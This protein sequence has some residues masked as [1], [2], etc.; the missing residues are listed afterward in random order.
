MSRRHGA[1]LVLVV[2]IASGCWTVSG[3]G[4]SRSGFNPLEGAITPANVATLTPGWSWTVPNDPTASVQGP[5]VVP[6][7]AYVASG[8]EVFALDPATGVQLWNTALVSDPNIVTSAATE[9]SRGHGRVYASVPTAQLGNS[10]GGT[11]AVDAST[12][13]G[14]ALVAREARSAVV[15]RDGR[16]VGGFEDVDPTGPF[17]PF[18]VAGY[19]VTDVSDPSKSWDMD[20]ATGSIHGPAVALPEPV[21]GADR[22]FVS[23][24]N[25]VSAY[26]LTKPNG[27]AETR[28]EYHFV[29]CP[30]LWSV[31]L[32]AAVNRRVT[33]SEDGRTLVLTAGP[34]IAGLDPADGSLDWFASKSGPSS[35]LTVPAVDGAT[36]FAVDG[37]GKLWAYDRDGCP[38]GQ[39]TPQWSADTGGDVVV[40]PTIA[41]GVVY[42]ATTG[43]VI[44]AFPAAG[45]GASTCSNLWEGSVASAPTGLAVALGRV[46]VATISKGLIT[47]VP[48][49]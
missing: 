30:S 37:A 38:G 2:L 13:T 45:C 8:R 44:R 14:R 28:P 43:G 12:G 39:C 18:R 16:I 19:F 41:G 40:Q 23:R 4:P 33:L 48:A 6:G 34:F 35:F 36:T 25:T 31:T 32:Q 24:G 5:A 26:P 20:I 7:G 27:C 17:E 22:F 21:V 10:G 3:G 9:P 1:L 47:F 42:T 11:F 46:F 49:A 29:E 15:P